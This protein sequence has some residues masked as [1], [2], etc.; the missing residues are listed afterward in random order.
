MTYVTYLDVNMSVG[1]FVVAV[2]TTDAGRHGSWPTY[3]VV[4]G[5]EGSLFTIESRTG[6]SIF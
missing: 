3:H 5:N 6:L 1:D 2:A 4:A